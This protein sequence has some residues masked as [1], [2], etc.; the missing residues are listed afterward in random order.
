M[1]LIYSFV[2][3]CILTVLS[4]STTDSSENSAIAITDELVKN[5]NSL[6]WKIEKEGH[7]TAY[8]FGTMHMIEEE[9]YDFTPHMEQIIDQSDEIVM[10]I[11]GQPNPLEALSMMTLKEGEVEDYFTKE[12]LPKLVAFMDTEMNIDPKQFHM[13]F[14]TMK[15]FFILQT[16]T[17]AYFTS[18]AVSYDMNIMQMA[19][20]KNIT[21]SGFETLEEQLGFFDKIP[22]EGIA[23]MIMTSVENFEE[24]KKE[25]LK[26]QKLYAKEKVDKLIPMMKNQSPEFMAFEDIFLTNRNKA[27]I[28]QII[29]KTK[30]KKCF[31]AVGAAHLFDTNGVINLLKQEGFTLTAVKK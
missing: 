9:Y 26:L 22:S 24:E 27:W 21:L 11:G 3:I 25:T 6:L 16:I 12:Q 2:A 8:I 20:E 19:G 5:E 14:S 17:Q 13:M 31:I 23:E 4:C 7:K 30:S 18:T 1:K 28:P 10:E 29:E 15:P